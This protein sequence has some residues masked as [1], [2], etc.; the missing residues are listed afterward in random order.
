MIMGHK[1]LSIALILGLA[2][3]PLV[4]CGDDDDDSSGGTSGSSG[5]GGTAGT[6][7]KSG[8]AGKGGSG[9]KAGS[10]T[11]GTTPGEGGEGGGSIGIGG[12]PA[13]GAGG[14]GGAAAGSDAGGEGGGA[15]GGMG[16][17]GGE[18]YSPEA[19]KARCDAICQHEVYADP[20]DT[21]SDSQPC[22]GDYNL[23]SDY[24]CTVGDDPTCADILNEYLTCVEN[25]AQELLYCSESLEGGFEGPLATDLAGLTNCES[26]FD[27]WGACSAAAN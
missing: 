13:G 26:T 2:S 16:G 23:C 19:F 10:G 21:T 20:L 1:T 25:S 15:M 8:T 7:G 27:A 3:L 4:A 9:G 5:K 22:N 14:A 17:M 11:A 6:A 24:L 18:S 12:E